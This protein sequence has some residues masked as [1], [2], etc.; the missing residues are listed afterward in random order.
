MRAILHEQETQDRIARLHENFKP[1]PGQII[2]GRQIFS[3]GTT[4]NMFQFG[5]DA[6]KSFG[7][8]YCK[9]R[10]AVTVPN[11]Y[12]VTVFP[13]RTQAQKA[14]WDSGY[15]ADKIPREFLLGGD[16]D[17]AFNKTELLIK[18][19]NGSR[20]Q[21]FGAD[22]PNTILRGPKPDFCNFDEF[23]DFRSG[24]YDVMEANLIGK[25]LNI[26]S[27]PPDTED[28]D[29]MILQRM[30]I[31][32]MKRRNPRYFYL[33][34]PTYIASARYQAP[35]DGKPPGPLYADLM[36]IKRTLERRGE[37]ARWK[38]E[39]EAKFI[40]GGVGSVF[41]KYQ[42]N[43]KHIERAGSFLKELLKDKRDKLEWYCI[44]D[45]SQNGTF[46]VLFIAYDRAAGIFYVLRE[47]AESDN[48]N[49]GSLD[50]WARMIAGMK[51]LY[52]Y[53]HRWHVVYDEAAAWF[54]NDLDRHG[55]FLRDEWW[56][57][58]RTEKS[59][60]D[61][62]EQMSLLKDIFAIR[63]KV[64]ISRDCPETIHQVE[65]YVTNK[66]G[67][68]HKEQ[69]DDFIDDLR[70]FLQASDFK[71]FEIAE[72]EVEEDLEPESFLERLSKRGREED[73][74]TGDMDGYGGDED[75]PD[76]GDSFPYE[77]GGYF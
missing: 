75:D 41:K 53:L 43:K 12:C 19:D 29:Y 21:V 18:L 30:F 55:V 64:F 40:P 39:Y 56:D 26:G 14:V 67:E 58:N 27:T 8:S 2:M 15:F 9:V 31:E 74:M 62:T 48:A 51:E 28:G 5:R 52:P 10:Y 68:Y 77:D 17:K 34:L 59:L 16:P 32:E 1:E 33:E 6:G 7:L 4:R 72:S 70:Y 57:F 23:R 54:Y 25:I 36:D 38:R 13:E 45:P 69:K 63:G 66:K 46:A 22:S 11:S 42:T 61:K 60:M 47:I 49:T 73:S 24:V 71:P 37:S 76:G 50:M 3:E 65:N 20:L 44:A 35:K